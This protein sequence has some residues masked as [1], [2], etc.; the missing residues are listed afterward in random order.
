MPTPM[1]QPNW[2]ELLEP[3]LRNIF[4]LQTQALVKASPIPRLFNVTT[5]P[6]AVEHLF[7]AGGMGDVPDYKGTIEYDS[8]D[9]GYKTDIAHDPFALGMAVQ[10]ELVDD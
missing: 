7:G 4:F 9:K 1:V 8:F 5:S 3:G 2:P 6:K 10:R